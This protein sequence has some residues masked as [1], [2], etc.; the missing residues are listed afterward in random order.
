ME[1][2]TV[3]WPGREV[4]Y[5]GCRDCTYRGGTGRFSFRI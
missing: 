2:G 5:P 4:F 3:H 1:V